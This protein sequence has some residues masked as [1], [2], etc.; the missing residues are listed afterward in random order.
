MKIQTFKAS[1]AKEAIEIVHRTLGPEAV[2]VN[3]RK[4]PKPGWQGLFQS[5]Q[6]EVS[7]VL[8]SV[9]ADENI[10]DGGAA[11]SEKQELQ[12]SITKASIQSSNPS[13]AGGRLDIVDDTPIEIPKAVA[14]PDDEFPAVEPV[15]ET[16]GGSFDQALGQVSI[17]EKQSD[18]EGELSIERVLEGIGV[19]PLQVER[20]LRLAKQ[21]FPNL[22]SCTISDQI[23]YI[24]HCLTDHWNSLAKVA[25][26]NSKTRK[27]LVGAPGVG[28]TTVLCKWLTQTVLAKRQ[29][30]KVWRLD[31]HLANTAEML[32]VHAEMLDVESSRVW[33]PEPVT[34][35]T[36]QFFD[37]PGVMSG[38]PSGLRALQDLANEVHPAEFILVLNSAYELD[39]LIRA[40]REFSDLPINGLIVTHLDEES[41]WSK[42][43]NLTLETGLPILYCSGGQDIPGDFFKMTSE[44]L[45][46]SVIQQLEPDRYPQT[47]KS[48]LN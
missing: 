25:E 44:M 34:D 20:L 26:D 27:V 1:S 3:I 16:I 36:I 19:L 11:A 4:L 43:W 38:D 42:L 31:G 48:A 28:K 6:V 18:R 33:Y 37:L 10:T 47:A 41:R 13:Q 23:Q 22:D 12:P 29:P 15:H 30:A 35:E 17:N 21:R 7:A 8:P 2:V 5:S 40:V 39:H 24:R 9:S 45:F 14:S 32:T 46:Q